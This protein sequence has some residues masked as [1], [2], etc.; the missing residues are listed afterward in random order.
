MSVRFYSFLLPTLSLPFG[1]RAWII[2]LPSEDR[3]TPI[4]KL[5]AMVLSHPLRSCRFAAC[6]HRP[7]MPIPPPEDRH[8]PIDK[9]TATVLSHP[10]RSCRFAACKHRPPM[11]IPP[12]WRMTAATKSSSSTFD[13]GGGGGNGGGV[14]QRRQRRRDE[15]APSGEAE[16]AEDT[17]AGMSSSAMTTASL[18][19]PSAKLGGSKLELYSM[20]SGRASIRLWSAR[21][22]S[23]TTSV[24]AGRLA[25]PLR[26]PSPLPQTGEFLSHPEVLL[27]RLKFNL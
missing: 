18:A 25:P 20:S 3:R 12:L 15:A 9:L 2:P 21:P 6:K 16:L 23:T 4:D 14:L 27:P 8:T 5:A 17:S 10:L 24:I 1:M 19:H 22:A 7:P 26:A 13:G 11:S